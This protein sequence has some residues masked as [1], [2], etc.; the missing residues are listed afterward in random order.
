MTLGKTL[1]ALILIKLIVLFGFLKVFFFPDL[2]K[3]RYD[4]DYDRGAFVLRHILESARLKGTDHDGNLRSGSGQLGRAQFALTAMYHWMFVPLTQGLSFLLA[5]SKPFITK[6][7]IRNGSG[8]T[9]FWMRLFAVNFAIG[10]RHRP[11]SRIPRSAPTGPTIR[12]WSEISYGAPLAFEVLFAFLSKPPFRCDV[13]RLDRVSPRFHLF[14]TW[15]VAIGSSL[16]PVWILVANAWMQRPVAWSSTP[17]WPVSNAGHRRGDHLPVRRH[18][19]PPCTSNH[20]VLSALFVL[21]VSSMVSPPKAVICA[22]RCAAS[23]SLPFSGS[24]SPFWSSSRETRRPIT[25]PAFSR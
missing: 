18:P 21:I 13:F 4:N 25:P 16:S 5:F 20:F 22:W 17:I 24:Y 12:G 6:P 15:M 7:S 11:D 1:W 3:T 19:F 2:L 23:W 9:R 8:I 14:S 10:H